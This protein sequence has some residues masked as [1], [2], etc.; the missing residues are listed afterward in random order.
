MAAQPAVWK[1]ALKAAQ[2]ALALHAVVA[3]CSHWVAPWR[4]V[5][6]ASPCAVALPAQNVAA[7]WVAHVPG[8]WHTQE[9]NASSPTF[10]PGCWV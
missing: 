4:H 7:H 3:V 1:H 2:S 6:H 10:A 5:S 8:V 9:P